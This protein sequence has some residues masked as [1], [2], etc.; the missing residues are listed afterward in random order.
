TVRCDAGIIESPAG[1]IAVCVLTSENEDRSWNDN[2]AGNRLCASIG[3]A[4]YE[5]F[6]PKPIDNSPF[7]PLVLKTGASGPW[8]E[9]LQRTLNA[10]LTPS[11]ELS[12]D[13]D[14]GSVTESAVIRFQ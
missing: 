9:A 7:E 8:V 12:I 3:R 13:G 1:P 5:H 6:N 2:N 14:F 4:V 11:P 10:R